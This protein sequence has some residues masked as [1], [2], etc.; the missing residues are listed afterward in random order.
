MAGI[1]RD[2][3]LLYLQGPDNTDPEA[4]AAQVLDSAWPKWREGTYFPPSTG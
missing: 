2:A 3:L 1:E 4:L